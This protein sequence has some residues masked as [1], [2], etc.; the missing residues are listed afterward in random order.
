VKDVQFHEA[1][2]IFP[3]MTGD[4]F[5]RL[6]ED[7]RK[8]G[9]RERIK[10]IDGLILDGRNRYRACLQVGVSARYEEI[11]T[12]DPIAYVRSLN[13]HRRHLT[14]TQLGLVAAKAKE[15]YEKEASERM[16]AGQKSGGRGKVKNSM[17]DLPQS[18]DAGSARDK[19]GQ[20]FGV[21]GKM[22]DYGAQV[23]KSGN[24]ELIEAVEQDRIALSTAARIS[25]NTPDQI[26]KTLENSQKGRRRPR[27]TEQD[28]PEAEPDKDARAKSKAIFRANEAVD[29][30][31]RIPKNDPLRKRGF[32][33]VTDWIKANK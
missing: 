10:T 20:D 27:P 16:H 5:D 18:L 2:N 31:K 23:L 12:D 4:D 26:A 21:S 13:E 25:S 6:V 8:N 11:K 24:P 22:V 1:A 15:Y 29:A 3:L 33:I 30:L 28:E 14:A 9:L 19:A 17:E 7:I 32:Q